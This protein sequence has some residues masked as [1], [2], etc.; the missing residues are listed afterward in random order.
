MK[1][2]SITIGNKVIQPGERITIGLPTPEFYSY[3][4]MYMP[5]HVIHGKK[6]G[7]CLVVCAAIHGDEM[8]GI[9]IIHKLLN[10]GLLKSIQGTL[11]AVPVINVYG[12]ISLTRNLP[13]RR[14]L[15]GSFPG[16]EKGSFAS[17]LAYH[18]T[19][20][21]LSKASHCIDIH[22]AEPNQV[23]MPQVVTDMTCTES[24]KMARAFQTPIILNS[25]AN[26]GLLW[27]NNPE[28]NVPTI[29]YEA[30]EV[31]RTDEIA[32]RT[33]VQGIVRVMRSL[34]MLPLKAKNPKTFEP[35][36]VRSSKWVRSP[37]SGICTPK[38]KLGAEVTEGDIIA[39]IY[40]PFGTDKKYQI[41]APLDGIIVEK[42]QLSLINEGDN[43]YR[44]AKT[45]EEIP[46]GF[47]DWNKTQNIEE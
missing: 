35:L 28:Y 17:R 46:S 27:Q 1:N 39:E 26:R 7:P 8:N 36:L 25:K 12:L 33:G 21:I 5:I 30:G 11:I 37:G 4:S 43:I 40:D 2:K 41:L 6:E 23:M 13:D 15:D 20:E 34:N 18:F 45:K 38:K 16:L 3:A 31:L 24:E 44:I 14:D 10:L 19:Q 47:T 29:L 9:A 32:I 42:N 22:S